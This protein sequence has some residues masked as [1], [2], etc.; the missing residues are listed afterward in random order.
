LQNILVVDDDF[1]VRRGISLM[2][3]GR[4]YQVFESE[5]SNDA[6]NIVA[7]QKLDLAICDLFIPHMDGMELAQ[8]IKLKSPG[9]KIILLTAFSDNPHAKKAKKIFKEDFM[10]KLEIKNRLLDKVDQ[11]LRQDK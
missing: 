4:G 7:N 3:K 10:E 5:D 9:T 2:L 11:I 1:A 6:L 8:E